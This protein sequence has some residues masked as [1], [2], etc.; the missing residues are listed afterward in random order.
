MKRDMEFIRN[1]ML[2]LEDLSYPSLS[3]LNSGYGELVRLAE[4]IRLMYEAGFVSGVDCSSAGS[5]EWL[6]L[7]LTWEGHDFLDSVRDPRIW[8]KTKATATRVGG[9]TA[10]ILKDLAKGF[11]RKQL[12]ELTGV[13]I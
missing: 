4:H 11:V 8:E 9:L 3:D 5:I 10:D 13:T 6:E 7:R 1:L 12:E 2:N